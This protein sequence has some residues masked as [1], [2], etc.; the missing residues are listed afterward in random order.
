MR[1]SAEADK[2]AAARAKATRRARRLAALP[3]PPADPSPADAFAVCKLC[4]DFLERPHACASVIAARETVADLTDPALRTWGAAWVEYCAGNLNHRPAW[5]GLETRELELRL[6]EMGLGDPDGFTYG[7]PVKRKPKD[8]RMGALSGRL[9]DG[10]RW[11]L[12]VT[13]CGWKYR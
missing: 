2:I 4:G 5:T 6:A 9:P 11:H 1:R 7:M 13:K 12:S 3:I 8:R 10:L